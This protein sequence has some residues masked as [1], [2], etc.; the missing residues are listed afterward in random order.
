[1]DT[2][3]PAVAQAP[4]TSLESAKDHTGL[5]IQSAKRKL[6]QQDAA[7]DPLL[8]KRARRSVDVSERL[9]T[10][11]RGGS[12]RQRRVVVASDDE[13]EDS[14]ECPATPKR[15]PAAQTEESAEEPTSSSQKPDNDT[16]GSGS[17]NDSSESMSSSLKTVGGTGDSS[18]KNDSS[19]ATSSPHQ[20]LSGT[21]AESVKNNSSEPMSSSQKT[22]SGTDAESVKDD[23]SEPMSSLR[24]T[25]SG[26]DAESFENPARDSSSTADTTSTVSAEDASEASSDDKASMKA[27]K[28]ETRM[29]GKRL[30]GIRGL[31][32]NSNQCFAN[33]VTQ[34]FDAALERHDLDMIL[35]PV[36]STEHPIDVDLRTYDSLPGH[37]AKKTR[38]RVSLLQAGIRSRIDKLRD[39]GRLEALSPRKHFRALMQRMRQINVKRETKS[40]AKSEAKSKAKDK[41]ESGFLTPYIFQQVLAYGDET[42]SRKHLDGLEQEDCYEYFQAVLAGLKDNSGV[43]PSDE[44]SAEKPAIIDSL[45]EFKTETASVCSDETCGH[46]GAVVHA[47]DNAQTV[48]A[49][50]IRR[51]VTVERLL[52][53]SQVS[54]LD[55]NCPKCGQ[56]TLE[57]V[58]EFK[59]VADNFV[60][61][62]N[63]VCE[64]QETGKKTKIMNA[65]ELPQ[66]PIE[67]CGRAYVL[68]A[69]IRHKGY[70]VSAGHYTILR[71][72]SSDWTI[73]DTATWWKFDDHQVSIVDVDEI[74][75]HRNDGQSAMLLFKAL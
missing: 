5:A 45:F 28:R 70:S 54:E 7:S 13:H 60:L 1:M 10:G 73:N 43:D 25:V 12:T 17:K 40:E 65:V 18:S 42:A 15:D 22:V 36:Q 9:L 58:T 47:T 32:N 8:S 46:R 41:D 24:E 53:E 71:R 61:H 20:S 33:A 6:T 14:N 44:E 75:D 66:K 30:R 19:E 50:K 27:G 34:L 52:T 31:L 63:R 49:I 35:G 55:Q 4:S 23:S 48:Q 72:R 26:T 69:I 3:A 62:I 16:D 39:D 57:R 74:R 29:E 11:C 68:D 56:E 21:D 51:K 38:S 2:V 64:N 37:G 67:I 59:E